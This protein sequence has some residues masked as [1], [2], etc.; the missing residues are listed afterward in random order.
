MGPMG[1]TGSLLP[2]QALGG[3]GWGSGSVWVSFQTEGLGHQRSVGCHPVEACEGRELPDKDR[4]KEV[5][6]SQKETTGASRWER[7]CH[8]QT[9]FCRDPHQEN[10]GQGGEEVCS[11]TPTK[12]TWRQGLHVGGT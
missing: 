2:A 9:C 11:D 5:W 1:S 12:G 3:A 10:R 4:E 7:G 8:R 6:V